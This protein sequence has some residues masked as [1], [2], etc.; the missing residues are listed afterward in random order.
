MYVHGKTQYY[1]QNTVKK[2]FQNKRAMSFFISLKVINKQ[3]SEKRVYSD[4]K[5]FQIFFNR[6]NYK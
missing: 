1:T 4:Y 6:G 5:Y 3:E 2:L